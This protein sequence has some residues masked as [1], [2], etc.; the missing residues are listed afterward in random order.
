MGDWDLEGAWR[1]WYD[2]VRLVRGYRCTV[3]PL[4]VPPP[5]PVFGLVNPI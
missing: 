3:F 4:K 2:R 1:T 5:F